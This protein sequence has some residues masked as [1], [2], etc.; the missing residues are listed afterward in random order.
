M[1]P[2]MGAL[3]LTCSKEH[4]VTIPANPRSLVQANLQHWIC[5][6]TPATLVVCA[7]HACDD[8]GDPCKHAAPVLRPAEWG[9]LNGA[10][11]SCLYAILNTHTHTCCCY[12]ARPCAVCAR[13]Y[14]H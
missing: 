14:L 7:R 8:D 13:W 5:S 3:W 6:A 2:C 1:W 4:L 10:T 11:A 9:T 12:P